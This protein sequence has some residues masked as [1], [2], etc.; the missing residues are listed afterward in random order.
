MVDELAYV[1]AGHLRHMTGACLSLAYAG[2]C[3]V[4]SRSGV[5]DKLSVYLRR[6]GVCDL[7]G[8]Q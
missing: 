8:G 7:S 3:E 2:R 6:S 4:A 5:E 1:V